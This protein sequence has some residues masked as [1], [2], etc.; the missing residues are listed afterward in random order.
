MT[1]TL[2]AVGWP[3]GM[4]LM[5][6]AAWQRPARRSQI[7]LDSRT[8]LWVPMIGAT[9]AV[10][11][12][13]TASQRPMGPAPLVLATGSVVACAGRMLLSFRDLRDLARVREQAVTDE[14]TGLGNRRLLDQRASAAMASGGGESLALLLIDLD[15]F[16]EVNDSLGHPAGDMLL[17]M[18]G[19]RLRA[20]AG[21][22]VAVSRLGGDEFAVLLAGRDAAEAAA[23]AGRVLGELAG[24]F[25]MPE[26]SIHVG[27]SIGISLYPAHALDTAGLLRCA[28]VAMYEAKR[29]RSGYGIYDPARDDSRERLALSVELRRALEDGSFVLH[30]QPQLR[31]ADGAQPS[32]EAL[33]RWPHP[34][35]GMVPPDVFIPLAEETRLIHQLTLRVVDL[36]VSQ[37][38]AWH[39]GGRKVSVSVNLSATDLL[40]ERL[41]ARIRESLDRAGLPPSSL[42]AEITESV[43][44]ADPHRAHK[45]VNGLR[46]AGVEVSIDDFGTGFS[47][48]SYLRTLPASE[49]KLDRSFVAGL[50]CDRTGRDAAIVRSVIDLAH[51][52]GMRAV[53]EGVEDAETLDILHR[54]G[55]DV[56]QGYSIA[57]PAPA[58]ALA[59]GPLLRAGPADG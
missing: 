56:A 16:K 8:T 57:R 27:A 12:L 15:R 19:P 18:A 40:D 33:L 43:L 6:V 41:P 4:V 39:R 54:F 31:L 21:D 5:S 17:R 13:L 42:V 29:S 59:P 53:A 52:L 36:A 7:R 48:L 24:E 10:G 50:S 3:T 47:S 46:H 26:T 34:T 32:L 45:V 14:L 2:P 55:C 25:V 38:A 51:A 20:A 49:V 35:R 28:D 9:A 30:Y 22:A 58:D 44:M 1:G 37:C 11:V 23:V